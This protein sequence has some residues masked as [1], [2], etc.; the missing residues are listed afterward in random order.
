M[1]PPPLL[2]NLAKLP[3]VTQRLELLHGIYHQGHYKEPPQK[4][5]TSRRAIF[6]AVLSSGS[7][8]D[9][10][11]LWRDD[12]SEPNGPLL[13]SCEH[14]SH[15]FSRGDDCSVG[16]CVSCLISLNKVLI[17]KAVSLSIARRD[18]KE[19]ELRAQD[20]RSTINRAM[21]SNTAVSRPTRRAAAIAS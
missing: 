16:K 15:A 10:C 4:G 8:S 21:D 2:V 20:L 19:C 13:C 6:A 1:K 17:M 14:G 5:M 12:A 3:A 9:A 7:A 11:G 18:V